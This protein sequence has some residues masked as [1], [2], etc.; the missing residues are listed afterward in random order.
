MAEK[1]L[2]YYKYMK[3]CQGGTGL[4]SLAM[5]TKIPSTKA[6]LL[7]DSPE[8]ILLFQ[9]AIEKLTGKAAPRY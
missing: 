9:Q 5:Q 8:S 2:R 6:A 3:E 7:P 1:L 4:I